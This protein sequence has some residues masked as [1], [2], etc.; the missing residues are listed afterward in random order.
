MWNCND[1]NKSG[2]LKTLI[3]K[4]KADN[5]EKIKCAKVYNPKKVKMEIENNLKN[6]IAETNGTKVS[7]RLQ[8]I[9]ENLE[10]LF[11]YMNNTNAIE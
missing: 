9:Y 8:K 6:I 3:D 10:E 5:D 4:L 7:D 2:S 11:E 1:C